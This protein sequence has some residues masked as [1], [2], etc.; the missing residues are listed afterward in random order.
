MSAS[1]DPTS[2]G[3][4]PLVQLS[5]TAGPLIKDEEELLPASEVE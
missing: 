2:V 1:T 4:P 5:A 3:A